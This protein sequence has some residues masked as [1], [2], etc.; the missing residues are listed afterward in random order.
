VGS[1]TLG[2][3]AALLG[4]NASIPITRKDVFEADP[5]TDKE[6]EGQGEPR[7]TLSDMAGKVL[8]WIPGEVIVLYGA[9]ITLF[10]QNDPEK[11]GNATTIILTVLGVIAAGGFVYLAAWS[12]T[13]T[14]QWVTKRIRGRAILASIAFLIWSLTVPNS[15]WNEIGWIADNPAAMAGIAGA[16]GL[17]FSFIATGF[18]NRFTDDPA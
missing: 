13:K 16:F 1:W 15:G 9:L 10:V 7:D 11:A 14:K 4:E 6:K 2:R 3:D 18:D 5:R 17:V 8:A 12:S